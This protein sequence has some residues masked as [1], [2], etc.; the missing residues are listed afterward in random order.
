VGWGEGD[1]SLGQKRCDTPSIERQ[2]HSSTKNRRVHEDA[3]VLF[4]SR[5]LEN[6]RPE[7]ARENSQA[8]AVESRHTERSRA[9][10]QLRPKTRKPA[11]LAISLTGI[12]SGWG[13]HLVLSLWESG[14]GSRLVGPPSWRVGGGSDAI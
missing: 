4:F 14:H 11:S 5:C 2:S 3:A 12:A 7:F 13:K 9:F 6:A 8:S 1:L 10:R